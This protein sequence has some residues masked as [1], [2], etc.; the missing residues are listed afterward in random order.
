MTKSLIYW[1]RSKLLPNV[2]R[3]RNFVF[4]VGLLVV[5]M[6]LRISGATHNTLWVDEA[7]SAINGLTIL[8][9]GLP[10]GEYLGIPIYE[11]TLTEPLEGDP[12]YAYRDSSY[13]LERKVAVYHGWLPLYA[14]AA[15]QALFGI[16]PSQA[17]PIPHVNPY[18]DKEAIF[19]RTLSAR[20]PAIVFSFFTCV[21]LFFSMN[22]VAGRTA[23]LASLAWFGL[24]GMVVW[25]SI[26]ARYY[27]LTLLMVALVA[28]VYF[29]TV[30]GGSWLS[31]ISF[32]LVE[33]LL[34]HTHQLSAV[35]FAGASLFGIP[36]I[37]RHPNWFPKSVAAVGIAGSLT[38]PWALWSGF[39][40]T[41]STV[42]TVYNLFGSL[43]D[44]VIYAYEHPRNSLWLF[45]ALVVV[46]GLIFF[47]QHVPQRCRKAFYA[48]RFYYLFLFWWM[49]LIY[50]SFH[51]LVPA[52]S[53]FTDRLTLMLLIPFIMLNGLLIG[54]IARLGARNWQGGVSVVLSV[55]SI[56]ILHRPAVFYGFGMDTENLAI[57]RLFD[58]FEEKDFDT[59]T[60]F[61]ATPSSQLV[62][63]YYTGLP[64]QSTVPVKKSF[65]DQYPGNIVIFD[66]RSFPSH[67]DEDLI[68][69]AGLERGMELTG[70][71]IRQV[72]LAL[73]RALVYQEDEAAGLPIPTE[74]PGLDEF[75]GSLLD[76]ARAHSWTLQ[77]A[78]IN[79]VRR[80]PVFKGVTAQT[81]DDYWLIFFLRFIDYK[82]H[83]GDKLNYYERVQ[84]GQVDY[85]AKANV[86][87]YLSPNAVLNTKKEK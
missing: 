18:H 33:G 81:L 53:Y 26:Q 84:N 68:A 8:E 31:F 72:Q 57:T 30:K 13:S 60:K 74:S 49:G 1:T 59:E 69:E 80:Y 20:M 6:L 78:L 52:A 19:K 7:E 55:I 85:L 71:E 65:F 25:F 42:P 56:V 22:Q 27:S 86:V 67:Y 44:W 48:N 66:T 16:E 5:A 29:R 75:E 36:S 2:G 3:K 47:P 64:I 4:A 15:S 10:L 73:W 17:G 35:V 82:N 21:V 41:A 58:Y 46:L 40:V 24:G 45:L 83:I 37:I 38:I 51:L 61:F 62:Y 87:V 39:F 54:D 32:G 70:F 63:T 11:N 12:V 9:K 28:Y 77:R 14:I 50:L 23:A 43:M 76:D 34:F 79:K